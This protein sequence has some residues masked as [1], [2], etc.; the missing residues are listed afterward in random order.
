MPKTIGI[1]LD[2]VLAATTSKVCLYIEERMN[3]KFTKR[4]MVSW[5]LSSVIPETKGHE[6]E[7]YAEVWKNPGQVELEDPDIPSILDNLREKFRICVVTASS[8]EGEVIKQ[9]LKKKGIAYEGFFHLPRSVDKHGVPGIDIYVDDH[10]LVAEN[11]ARSGKV[12]IL[13]RQ[14]WNED[15]I[16]SNGNPNIIPADNWRHVEEIL[17]TRFAEK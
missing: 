4:D 8:G 17:L 2:D 1:D 5:N 6:R 14:P 13:L 7:I 15:F 16:K 12:V 10:V 11:V 9:W 3:V